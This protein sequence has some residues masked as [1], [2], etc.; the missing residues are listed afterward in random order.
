VQFGTIAI[1]LNCIALNANMAV[2]IAVKALLYFAYAIVKLALVY[3]AFSC[4][5]GINDGI[6]H[7]WIYKF[8][9][10]QRC[11]FED[12]FFDEPFYV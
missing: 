5:F 4:H 8:H 2:I 10:Y 3:L 1:Y 9:H 6:G 7:F 12:C 11:F